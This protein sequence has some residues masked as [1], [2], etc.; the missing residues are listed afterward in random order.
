MMGWPYLLWWFEK[1]SLRPTLNA[2][3]PMLECLVTRKQYYLRGIRRTRKCDLLVEVCHWDVGCGG[4]KSPC[5]SSVSF[6]ILA[7]ESGHSSQLL[8]WS[9]IPHHGDTELSLWT[10]NKPHTKWFPLQELPC[11]GVS[12]V[13]EQWLRHTGMMTVTGNRH[14]RQI[15]YQVSNDLR[16]ETRVIKNR[17]KSE[18]T[19]P[20]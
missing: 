14:S 18:D 2:Q 10:V 19:V 12:S 13:R 17:W 3:A 15:E 20:S 7:C 11:H 16:F 9:H 1:E 8:L 5:R 6:C 4:F